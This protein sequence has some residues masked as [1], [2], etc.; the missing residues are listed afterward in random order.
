MS[1]VPCISFQANVVNNGVFLYRIIEGLGRLYLNILPFTT[2]LLLIIFKGG[3]A[4]EL[5]RL[6]DTHHI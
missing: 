3:A 2:T 5:L 6:A 1:Q 4:N